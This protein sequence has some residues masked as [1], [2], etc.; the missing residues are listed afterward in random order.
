MM[1]A[2]T[3]KRELLK[4]RSKLFQLKSYYNANWDS[5]PLLCSTDQ[6]HPPVLHAQRGG[7]Q[8]GR[9]GLYNEFDFFVPSQPFGFMQDA[10]QAVGAGQCCINSG[11]NGDYIAV[12]DEPR[13]ERIS[14]GIALNIVSIICG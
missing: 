1:V 14:I 12:R 4:F 5:V 13:E 2:V 8:H 10:P 3:I 9:H 11:Y 6:R 7:A